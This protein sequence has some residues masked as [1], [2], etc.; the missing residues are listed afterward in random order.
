[1]LR[2]IGWRARASAVR[3]S[4][5]S[6][7]APEAAVHQVNDLLA[8]LKTSHT[9]LFTP[10]DYEYYILLDIVGLRPEQSD[11]MARR[12]WGSGL[13]YPASGLSPA[14]SKDVILSTAFWKAHLPTARRGRHG[15]P[16]EAKTR[17]G[18]PRSR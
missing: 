5:L 16:A 10:D 9:A 2:R 13:Y 11:L 14:R 8:E 3:P 17:P 7:A 6:A 15:Y 12:F 18:R 1:M 4:V